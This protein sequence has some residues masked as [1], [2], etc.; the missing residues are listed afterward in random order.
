MSIVGFPLLLIPL[1]ICNII[2]FLMPGLGFDVALTGLALPSG[3]LWSIA[4]GDAVVALGALLLLLEVIKAGRPGGKY[5]T[6]QLLSLLVLAGTVGEF[7]TLPQFGNATMFLL[8]ILALV[9]FLAGIALRN[10]QQRTPRRRG[11]GKDVA[12]QPDPEPA[13]V[14][15]TPVP[16]TDPVPA[17]ATT[18]EASVLPSASAA[19]IA[20]AVLLDRPQPVAPTIEVSP[21]IPSPGLQP[22]QD[23]SAGASR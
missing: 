3:R 6:D 8:S 17:T 10:R 16:T 2:V 20:E 22:G 21:R 1:A 7:V 14:A 18:A 4:L 15:Q 11:G 5:V 12:P 19:S 23:A 9:D 13:P